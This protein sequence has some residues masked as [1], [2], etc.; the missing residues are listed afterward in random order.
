MDGINDWASHPIN[1]TIILLGFLF[2]RTKLPFDAAENNR[3]IALG[4][5]A[6]LTAT[7]IGGRYMPNIGD[8]HLH[9]HYYLWQGLLMWST[10]VALMGFAKHH[11]DRPSPTIDYCNKAIYPFFI[12]HQTVIIML[13]WQVM[14]LGLNGW[15]EFFAVALGTFGVCWVLYEGLIRHF[16]PLRLVFGMLLKPKEKVRILDQVPAE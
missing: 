6:I 14:K 3:F 10:I 7:L 16:N 15:V 13:A 5:A 12:L 1:M 9:T 8:Y 4:I 2:V 11:L